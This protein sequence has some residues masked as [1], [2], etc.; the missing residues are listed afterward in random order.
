[1]S[2]VDHPIRQP[3]RPGHLSHLGSYY[4]SRSQKTTYSS[5][6]CT[7]CV[8][9]VF[10]CWNHTE[11]SVVVIAT[12]YGLDGC[13]VWFRVPLGS[14]IFSSPRRPKWLWG[15]PNRLSNGYWGFS[16]GVKRTGREADHSAPASAEVKK[17]WIYIFTPHTPSQ[18][19]LY[20]TIHR[21]YLCSDDFYSDS[22]LVLGFIRA[23]FFNVLM[24]CLNSRR[25]FVLCL[26]CIPYLCWYRYPEIETSSIDW[27]HLSRLILKTETESGLRNVV[28]NK[29]RT[30]DNVQKH[31][32]CINMP[33]SQTFR[34]YS[35]LLRYSCWKRCL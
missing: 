33:P 1:M 5:V 16:P 7:L 17:M 21:I 18:G 23:E 30:M 20:L 22:T 26:A 19:Q 32:S 29:N 11:N 6:Q 10:L 14:R 12:G 3:S 13:G 15:P 25:R 9:T 34:S 2:L 4:R 27:A 31:N 24:F 28:L 8:K 35:D